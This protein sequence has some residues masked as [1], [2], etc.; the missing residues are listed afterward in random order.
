M[1]YFRKLLNPG[2]YS[3]ALLMALVCLLAYQVRPTY[4]IGVGTPLDVSLVRGFNAPETTPGD[5]PQPFRWS[6]GASFVTLR[7]VGRQDFRVTITVNGERP[8]GQEAPTL[9]VHVGDMAALTVSPPPQPTDYTFSVPSEAVEDGTLVIR[10]AS[11][12][13]VPPGDPNPRR[14]GVVVTQVRV[15]PVPGPGRF[16]LPPSRV[17]AALVGASLLLGLLLSLLGWG[18]GAT[19][20]GSSLLALLAGGLLVG[21]RLWLTAGR[22]YVEWDTALVAAGC[23]VALVAVTAMGVAKRRSREGRLRLPTLEWRLLLTLLLAVF[24]VRLA[25]QLHPNIYIPDLSFHEHRFSTVE[26]GRLLFTI[27]SDEWGGHSTFYLPTAYIFMLPLSRLLGD[28]FLIIK[29]FTVGVG[30]LGAALLYLIGRGALRSGRA[31]L[32]AAALYLLMPISVLPF[33]WGITTNLF[34][35][36]FALCALAVMLLCSRPP[37]LSCPPRLAFWLL[38]AAMLMALL[39]HP[40]VVQLAGLAFGL[41]GLLWLLFGRRHEQTVRTE[42]PGSRVPA[43]FRVLGALALAAGVSYLIYYGHFAADMLKTLGEI[44]RERAAAAGPGGLH[45]LVGGSVSDRSLGLVVNYADTW[46]DWLVG[47]LRGFWRE[48]TAYYRV[49]PL[50]AA[51]LGYLLLWP[52]VRENSRHDQNRVGR[53]RLVLAALGWGGVALVY[54]VIG[55]T[56]NLYVRYALFALPMVSLGAGWLLTRLWRKGWA[57]VSLVYL[58]LAFFSVA[59]LDLW[60][61]RISYAF[62]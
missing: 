32:L 30:T 58:V 44:R 11:N 22:W 3:G 35:E 47:G 33:S 37:L 24:A 45:L 20:L 8:A 50:L 34:G 26:S 19:A 15:E 46:G 53:R 27:Q 6:T 2:I 40:G 23:F 14:L 31:G 7:D 57:G 4:V 12:T 42:K 17:W 5:P 60:Q 59:A 52:T 62:K 21:A 39:S 43:G 49:W 18:A 54:A 55:W 25:G 16:I 13:F 36:F 1:L 9:S 29:L 28:E 56:M 38:T 51:A 41:T 48:A 61:Y 10:L